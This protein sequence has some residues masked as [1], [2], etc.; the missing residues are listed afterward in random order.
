[1][2]KR[3]RSVVNIYNSF[4]KAIASFDANNIA[5]IDE[6]NK[7]QTS[8][9]EF[10]SEVDSFALQLQELGLCEGDKILILEGMSHKLYIALVALF[11]IGATAVFVDPSQSRAFVNEACKIAS[12]KALICSKKALLLKLKF[13]SIREIKHTIVTEKNFFYPS[14]KYI[15]TDK[16]EY[17]PSTISPL[18]PALMTFTSGSTATPKAI[19]RTH[20]FLLDQYRVLKP[21]INLQTAQ[22]DLSALP[23]FL[24]ANLFAGVTS[25]IADVALAHPKKIN[26]YKLL[27]TIEQFNVNRIGASPVLFEKLLEGNA[28]LEGVKE[29][30][31]GGAAVMPSLLRELHK[32][33]PHINTHV[34]YGSSEA[35]PISSYSFK[36]LT[37]QILQKMQSGEGLFVGQVVDEIELDFLEDGEIIV[38]GKHVVKEYFKNIGDKEN[39]IVIDKK[40]W[41]KT[42][43]VGYLDEEKNLWLL[44]RKSAIIHKNSKKIYPFSIEVAAREKS[45]K[46]AALVEL[47]G[48]VILFS[49][50]KGTNFEFQDVD[51][52]RYM[53][54]I[55]LDKRHNAKVDYVALKTD[56][57]HQT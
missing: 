4:L 47:E 36:D 31:M 44:G 51:E 25:V 55:P 18:T 30:Y 24:L 46:M 56:L 27:R 54:K 19:V 33:Y 38:E 29:C 32:K 43:D 22:R 49:E 50:S 34:L 23:I 41:H 10:I 14:M 40:I 9:K 15:K 7:T 21:H 16:R 1:M 13:S 20:Q 12:A 35:E 3:E 57:T 8:F 17:L 28:K 53:K 45:H 48:R 11:K 5:I 26:S 6:K 42:G 39:K 37:E 2:A 52:V